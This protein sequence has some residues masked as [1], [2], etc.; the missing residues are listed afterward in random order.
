M[1]L[2]KIQQRQEAHSEEAITNAAV[3][4]HNTLAWTHGGGGEAQTR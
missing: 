3:G 2:D 4:L 1:D